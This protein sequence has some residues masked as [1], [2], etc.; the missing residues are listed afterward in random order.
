MTG[1]FPFQYS[2]GTALTLLMSPPTTPPHY[3]P[4]YFPLPMETLGPVPQNKK[5]I[6]VSYHPGPNK[7]CPLREVVNGDVE[8]IRFMSIL[9]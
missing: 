6:K 3:A 2:P 7:L 4:L 5:Q 9:A 8:T 1:L